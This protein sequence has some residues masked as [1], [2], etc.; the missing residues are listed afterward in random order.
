MD[1]KKIPTSIGAIVLIVIAVTVSMFIWVYERSQGWDTDMA[2]MRLRSVQ[3]E[4]TKTS[5]QQATQESLLNNREL[6]SEA[7][8]IK[9]WKKYTSYDESFSMEFPGDWQV[10]ND[11]FND[12]DNKKIAGL[13]GVT[14]P[15]SNQQCF[16]DIEENSDRVTL[17]SKKDSVINDLSITL[18]I[19]RAIKDPGGGFWFPNMYCI[20]KENKIFTMTFYD[21]T[22]NSNKKNLFDKIMSTLDLK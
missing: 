6:I 17:I 1:N 3:K 18:V 16:E 9:G 4:T 22:L 14:I 15:Q 20:K 7:T 21:D 8:L 11:G 19:L 12:V 13:P 2:V 5:E 10:N